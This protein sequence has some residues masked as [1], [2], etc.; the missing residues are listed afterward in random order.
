MEFCRARMP[1]YMVPKTVICLGELPK[2]STG[3]IK[4]FVLRERANALGPSREAH[5]QF[6]FDWPKFG[7]FAVFE[8]ESRDQIN[9]VMVIDF[10]LTYLS[11]TA[12]THLINS[13]HAPE[14]AK[15]AK[16]CNQYVGIAAVSMATLPHIF[17][18]LKW[19][20]VLVIYIFAPVLAFYNYWCMAGAKDNGVIAGLAACGVMMN[21]VST[22]LDLM[23]DFKTG[24]MT[25]FTEV[26]VC[27]PSDWNHNGLCHLSLC[28]L[29]L[30]QGL[31]QHWDSWIKVSFRP[32]AFAR[33]PKHGDTECGGIRCAVKEHFAMFSLWVIS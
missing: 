11:G 21:M 2:T 13:F 14:G 9:Q 24:Y 7:L 23:Q 22:A 18:Q 19:Y 4:K 16:C 29:P 12:T 25:S 20:Y 27:E 32:S 3:K 26:H 30:S 1:H 17:H 31:P 5:A 10:R 15:L 28:F 6:L 33:V 8:L